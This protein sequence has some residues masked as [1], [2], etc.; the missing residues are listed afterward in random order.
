M[1]PIRF[2]SN[3]EKLPVNNQIF[4]NLRFLSVHFSKPLFSKKLFWHL[5]S[6]FLLYSGLK[7]F[8]DHKTHILAWKLTIKTHLKNCDFKG[9]WSMTFYPFWGKNIKSRFFLPKKSYF[10]SVWIETLGKWVFLSLF[11]QLQFHKILRNQRISQILDFGH[12]LK[13]R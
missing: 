7:I 2:F 6:H 1:G 8:L 12:Y 5:F 3:P 9:F 10:V 13:L 11:S 4:K